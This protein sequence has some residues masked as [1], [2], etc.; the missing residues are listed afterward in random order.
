MDEEVNRM[1]DGLFKAKCSKCGREFDTK[2]GEL[3]ST[4]YLGKVSMLYG[5]GGFLPQCPACGN[6]RDNRL[7][8]SSG[9]LT[10]PLR[11]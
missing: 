3:N 11:F 2:P 4:E 5:S 8:E 7:L 6:W 10:G 9:Q 1:R